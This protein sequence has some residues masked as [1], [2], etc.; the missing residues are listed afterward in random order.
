MQCIKTRFSPSPSGFLHLGSIRT[1]LYAWLFAKKQGGKFILRIDDTNFSRSNKEAILNIMKSLQW[2]RL[3][4]DEGPFF[5]SKR[6]DRYNDVLNNMLRDGYVYKCYCSQERLNILRSKQILNKEKPR[7]DGYC[8]F[9]L[10]NKINVSG[11]SPF[12][13]RFCNPIQGKTIFYDLIRGFIEFDNQELDDFIIKR[14]DGSWTYNFCSVVD[15]IDMNISHVFRGDEHINNTPK[16]INVFKSLNAKIPEYVHLSMVLD[17]NK[18]KLSKRHNSTSVMEYFRKGFLPDALLNYLVRLGWSYKDMEIFNVEDMVKLFNVHF[19][20]KSSGML[21]AKKLLWLNAYYIRHLPLDIVYK[22]YKKYIVSRRKF[23]YFQ[24]IS[25]L[26]QL[27]SVFRSR[28]STF[29]DMEKNFRYFYQDFKEID[30]VLVEKYLLNVQSCKVL[31][32]VRD[33]I[34][35]LHSWT[36][37]EIGAVL[38]N[39]S[40]KFNF[41]ISTLYM[42]IRVALM[43]VSCSPQLSMVMYILGKEKSLERINRAIKIQD[44]G[45]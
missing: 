26:L 41:E 36:L 28:C 22:Y 37:E 30:S 33:A 39:I 42:P 14:S 45:I 5:Q 43:S 8:R 25:K 19:L 20:N 3:Y 24:D 27:I 15:D 12:V 38:G 21:N 17:S 18:R 44:L 16:Q 7:Y 10:R 31:K 32:I 11:N 1:A 6:F 23:W 40:K 35:S 9:N 34:I 29:Q 2:L 13:V 4:W